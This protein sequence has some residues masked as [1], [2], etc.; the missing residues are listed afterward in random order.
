MKR[1]WSLV[2]RLVAWLVGSITVVLYLVVVL[3]DWV[4]D[5]S[6]E[7]EFDALAIEELAELRAGILT[8]GLDRAHLESI[9]REV[10]HEHPDLDLHVGVWLGPERSEWFAGSTLG[11]AALDFAL[12]PN[13]DQRVLG[14]SFALRG[15]DGGET[16][17]QTTVILD[18]SGRRRSFERQ[19]KFFIWLMVGGGV[20][21]LVVGL[22]FARRLARLFQSA[23]AGAAGGGRLPTELATTKR[24]PI[25]VRRVVDAFQGSLAELH[26]AHARNLLLTAG[27]AHELRS[28]LQN[29]MSEAEVVLLR[30]RGPDE[31]RRVL[32]TQLEE[33]RSLALV[34]DNLITLTALRDQEILPRGERFDLAHELRMRCTHEEDDALRRDVEISY[35]FAGDCAITADREALVLMVRNLLGNAIRW[36][37][38]GS[39]VRLELTSAADTL[40][41]VV[42]DAG[43]G[44]APAE[45]EAI[46]EAF[47]VGKANKGARAGYGLGLAL[48][49]TAARASGGEIEVADRPGGGTRFVVTLPRSERAS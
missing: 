47:Y 40:T 35:A 10:R 13:R 38:S 34:V 12:V 48:A 36:A 9:L 16:T 25:E 29:L 44:I 49:R 8:V 15:A 6:L 22:T 33:L 32:A 3:A 42:E 46:F 27:L 14:E 45:R 17:V 23:A 4:V 5:A 19:V 31:Y 20:V 7:R 18:G 24:L 2:R 43:P 41:I 28:P 37:P 39:V 1:E 30:D 21:T 26:A 11:D